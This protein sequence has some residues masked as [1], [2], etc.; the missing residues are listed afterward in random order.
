MERI[1]N[2]E[3]SVLMS[4]KNFVLQ[5]TDNRYICQNLSSQIIPELK[6]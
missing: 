1:K 2:D 6:I 4:Q 3:I 5:L